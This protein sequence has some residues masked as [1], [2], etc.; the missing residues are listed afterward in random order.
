MKRI[1]GALVALSAALLPQ[2]GQAASFDCAKAATFVEKAICSRAS[3]SR[4][5]DAL[6]DNYR[7]MRAANI[8][9]GARRHLQST[10]KQWLAER[11]R[12]TDERCVEN[13]YRQRIDEVCEYPVLAGVH[14]GCVAADDIR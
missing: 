1:V 4:L 5:D 10:Q 13:A 3:L 2:L 8:G 14:P 11:N 6:A 12:C 9:D 7:A